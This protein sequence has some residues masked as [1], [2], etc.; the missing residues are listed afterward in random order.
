MNQSL[1]KKN[2]ITQLS[3]LDNLPVFIFAVCNG[4]DQIM[5]DGSHGHILDSNNNKVCKREKKM[6]SREKSKSV[7][8]L[9][10]WSFMD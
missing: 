10:I 2:P 6:N 5:N 7:S 3:T 9:S 8:A 4:R 1:L